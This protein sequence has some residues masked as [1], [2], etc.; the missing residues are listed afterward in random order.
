M[1][2]I[3]FLP[4]LHAVKSAVVDVCLCAVFVVRKFD[5]V[6]DHVYLKCHANAKGKT[7]TGQ[8]RCREL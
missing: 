5:K 4:V 8:I 6:Y 1:K 3:V 2:L 7:V